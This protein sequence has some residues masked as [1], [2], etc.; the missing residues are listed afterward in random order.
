MWRGRLEISGAG[1]VL[2]LSLGRWEQHRTA[3][4][5][6]FWLVPFSPSLLLLLLAPT[7][8]CSLRSGLSGLRPR[9]C[10]GCVAIPEAVVGCSHTNPAF[11]SRNVIPVG[12]VCPSLIK[13]CWRGAGAASLFEGFLPPELMFWGFPAVLCGPSGWMLPAAGAQPSKMWNERP[14]PG[15]CPV[16]C[17]EVKLNKWHPACCHLHMWLQSLLQPHGR[18]S[19]SCWTWCLW[20]GVF[21]VHNLVI[22][23]GHPCQME[24]DEGGTKQHCIFPASPA[25]AAVSGCLSEH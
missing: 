15:L 25:S 11:C 18:C 17:W 24:E 2:L 7:A 13:P 20:L 9:H 6:P 22:V 1:S 4:P 8:G 3:F 14:R 10:T 12:L 19:G 5:H 23:T 16:W 21:W